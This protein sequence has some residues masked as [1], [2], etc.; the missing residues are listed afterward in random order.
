[1]AAKNHMRSPNGACIHGETA[2][3]ENGKANGG[4]RNQH[5]RVPANPCEVECNLFTEIPPVSAQAT[6]FPKRCST[7]GAIYILFTRIMVAL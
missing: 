7:R 1:M 2:V 3:E 4:G 6:R 5:A